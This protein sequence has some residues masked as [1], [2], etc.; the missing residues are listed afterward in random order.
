MPEFAEYFP[1]YAEDKLSK[2]DYLI[3]ITSTLEKDATKNLWKSPK[4]ADQ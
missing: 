1:D 2:K 3:S 4:I